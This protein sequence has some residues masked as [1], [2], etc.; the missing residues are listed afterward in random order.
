MPNS[1]TLQIDDYED[2]SG[3]I[4]IEFLIFKGKK[5]KARYKIS[6]LNSNKVSLWIE[7]GDI[8]IRGEAEVTKKVDNI[9][10]SLPKQFGQPRTLGELVCSAYYY[11]LA[12]LI[13]A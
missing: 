10:C 13:H 2:N 3:S 4:K 5:S 6:G 7:K 8:T 12:A 9:L 11:D 1:C